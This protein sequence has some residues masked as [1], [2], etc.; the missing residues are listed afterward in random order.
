MGLRQ[1][2]VSKKGTRVLIGKLSEAE[3]VVTTI[4]STN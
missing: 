2:R 1:E 4:S 3:G